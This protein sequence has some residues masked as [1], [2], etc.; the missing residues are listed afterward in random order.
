MPITLKKSARVGDM[1]TPAQAAQLLGVS[2][3]YLAKDRHE[4][5]LGGTP[6]KVPYMSLGHRSV[7]YQRSDLQSFLAA[8]R[9]G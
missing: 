5:R 3:Q 6:P 2:P 9:V 8:R 4:A 1:L 7:R